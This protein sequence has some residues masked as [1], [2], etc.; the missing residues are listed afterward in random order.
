M[1]R[2]RIVFT[3]LRLAI[4][5]AMTSPHNG[6]DDALYTMREYIVR[7]KPPSTWENGVYCG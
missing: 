3:P 4:V 2:L 1:V 7:G 6:N 5:L